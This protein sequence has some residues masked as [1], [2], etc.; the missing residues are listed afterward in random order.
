[1]EKPCGD[2][3]I[4]KLPLPR[5][6]IQIFFASPSDIFAKVFEYIW[7]CVLSLVATSCVDNCK[8]AI[9]RSWSIL[10]IIRKMMIVAAS[11]KIPS[12]WNK[13]VE[14]HWSLPIAMVSDCSQRDRF[15]ASQLDAYNALAMC[16]PARVGF[17]S[18]S[19]LNEI[20]ELAVFWTPWID[21]IREKKH[22]IEVTRFPVPFGQK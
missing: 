17:L 19:R 7:C 16:P 6:D 20:H 11:R 5:G 3:E 21:A 18:T 1:M 8:S 13:I 2:E 22:N 12:T 9:T 4:V 14:S 10:S 15:W